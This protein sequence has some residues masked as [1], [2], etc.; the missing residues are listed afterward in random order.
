MKE[1]IQTSFTH[2]KK[3]PPHHRHRR[4]ADFNKSGRTGHSPV[5]LQGTLFKSVGVDD[6]HQPLIAQPKRV[7][8]TSFIEPALSEDGS[9][10]RS[11]SFK[12]Q[13]TVSHCDHTRL[14][15]E[16]EAVT[17]SARRS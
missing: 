3:S 2:S 17:L 13:K 11:E 8:R 12:T 4:T 10:D 7:T 1:E 5:A 16:N 6:F 9:S 14:A 15:D